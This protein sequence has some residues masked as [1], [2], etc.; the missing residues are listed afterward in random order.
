MVYYRPNGQN[1]RKQWNKSYS[2]RVVLS[3]CVLHF[4]VSYKL[5]LCVDAKESRVCILWSCNTEKKKSWVLDLFDLVMHEGYCKRTENRAQKI[6]PW[7]EYCHHELQIKHTQKICTVLWGRL[8]RFCTS[9]WKELDL[10]R[11][12]TWKLQFEK[13]TSRDYK[14]SSYEISWNEHFFEKKN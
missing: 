7:T 2:L 3:L 6:Q 4:V 5:V 13:I 12:A 14:F 1:K 9:D 10:S 8:S 11:S